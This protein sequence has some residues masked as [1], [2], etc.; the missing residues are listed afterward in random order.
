M[1]NRIG[2]GLKKSSH[3]CVVRERHQNQKTIRRVDDILR[4]RVSPD[5][6]FNRKVI[7]TSCKSKHAKYAKNDKSELFQLLLLV[8][9]L[10][11]FNSFKC[12]FIDQRHAQNLHY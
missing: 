11:L 9:A 5:A 2:F 12:Y 10:Q 6:R 7:K 1:P 3:V 8:Y 4:N